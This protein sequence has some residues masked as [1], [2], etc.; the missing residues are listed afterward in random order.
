MVTI[1]KR[2]IVI[3][4]NHIRIINKKKKDKQIKLSANIK[5]V[6]YTRKEDKFY[7]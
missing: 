1:F 7:G 5:D 6:K 2:T 3:N 4:N